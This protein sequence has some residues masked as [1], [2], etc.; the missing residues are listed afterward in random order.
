MF[1]YTISAITATTEFA[2]SVIIAS[3]FE[4]ET[5]DSFGTTI[6]LFFTFT[7]GTCTNSE[8]AVIVTAFAPG[9]TFTSFIITF[10]DFSKLSAFTSL[11]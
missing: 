1:R 9:A 6:S 8:A 4:K 2:G 7:F 10:K 3:P 11:K 5:E